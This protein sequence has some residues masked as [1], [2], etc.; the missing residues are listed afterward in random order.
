[1]IKKVLVVGYLGNMGKR[2]C[3]ILNYLGVPWQGIDRHNLKDKLDRDIGGILIATPTSMH[4]E[5]IVRYSIYDLPI[6]CE[7]PITKSEQ[8]LE[9]IGDLC[10]N[11]SVLNQYA[12]MIGN[13][14][15]GTTYVDYY[16]TGADGLAWDCINLVGLSTGDCYLR[17][18]SPVWSIILNG[19][20]LNRSDVDVSYVDCIKHWLDVYPHDFNYIYYSHKRILEYEKSQCC[21]RHTGKEIVIPAPRKDDKALIWKCDD[22]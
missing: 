13:E 8:E 4:F 2:Y 17:N 12:F 10:A 18:V 3:S 20:P 9:T 11:L 1:M 5:N 22:D 19:K 14:S 6:L 15:K 21:N 16:N 7:K